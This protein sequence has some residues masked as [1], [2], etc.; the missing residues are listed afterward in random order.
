MAERGGT[1]T[2]RAVV[3]ASRSATLRLGF[4]C[5]WTS[6][7]ESTWSGT[8]WQLRRHLDPLAD[9]VDVGSEL[10]AALRT[11]L[12]LAYAR[13]GAGRWTS[14]WRHGTL[15][16]AAVA[17]DVDR[18]TRRA[19]PDVVLQIQDLGGTAAPAMVL[20]DL[21][22][23][24]LLDRYG[25]D[26]VPHFRALGRR[27]IES[28]RRAQDRVYARAAVLLPMSRWLADDLVAHGVPAHRVRVVHP[29]VNAAVPAGTPVPPRRRGR[30]RRLLLLGRDFDTKGGDQVVRALAVLRRE[31]GATV[32][33]TVAGPERWPMRG[34]VPDGVEF[35]GPVSRARAGELMDTHDLFVM[36]SRL[37]GFGIVFA[38]AL[39]R[40]LPC[41]GRDACAM[42]E[43][44]DRASGGLLVRSEAPD[45]LAALVVEALADDALYEACAA[46]ADARRAHFSWDRAARDVLA[47]AGTVVD[48]GRP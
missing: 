44:L 7:R 35:L 9:V 3:P 33:L 13:R 18:R 46:R 2:L 37:E 24:L 6:P 12:R 5:H 27:R 26:G 8:P 16:R 17:R 19:A 42:P 45:E 47:A 28:L 41:I 14:V 1:D 23:A 15:T 39:S 31:L 30:V 40:G 10:P 21:S 29:G 11:P 36:P 22:Y 43:I 4:A 25:R 20:Q 38:E 32:T 48:G 34:D